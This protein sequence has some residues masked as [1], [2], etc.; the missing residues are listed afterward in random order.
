MM[1]VLPF[2]SPKEAGLLHA[3]VL[4][5]LFWDC[6]AL[7][8]AGPA[9]VPLGCQLPA[10]LAMVRKRGSMASSCRDVSQP[11]SLSAPFHL[12]PFSQ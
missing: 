3:P 4:S 5:S 10:A 11:A 9:E 8:F 7:G 1:S 12:S 6:A 2:Y